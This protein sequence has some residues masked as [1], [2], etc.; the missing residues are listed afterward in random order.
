MSPEIEYLQRET[1]PNPRHAVIWLHGLGADGGDFYP[2]V[3]TLQ[4]PRDRPVR[5]I[6]PHAPMRPVTINAGMVMRAW[7]DVKGLDFV[8][9]EDE[10]GF[11][12]SAHIVRTLIESQNRLGIPAEN[13][14]LAGFSQGG[15]VSLHA[16]LR[17]PHR[18]AGI[19][20]LSAYLPFADR[21]EDEAQAVNRRTP[22]FMAH[23]LFDPVVPYF[24]GENSKNLLVKAGY[25][26]SWKTYAMQHSV[27]DE[28]LADISNWLTQCFVT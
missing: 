16:G 20:C 2:I 7:Y 3:P 5:F 14:V 24:L 17:H 10:A 13:I 23:G 8:Q 1:G 6:F 26:V 28:E 11:A 22:I 4:L 12:D 21:L 18:L 25:L 27:N 9:R 15:A 19:M